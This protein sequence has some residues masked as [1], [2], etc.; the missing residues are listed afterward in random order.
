MHIDV[1]ID[2]LCLISYIKNYRETGFTYAMIS[3]KD[4]ATKMEI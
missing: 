1:V 4:I 3:L 2:Q